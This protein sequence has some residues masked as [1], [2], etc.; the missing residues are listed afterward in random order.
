MS[1]RKV[2]Y[3]DDVLNE[4]KKF[5]SIT[6]IGI[7]CAESN[8]TKASVLCD[9]IKLHCKAVNKD[10]LRT[11]TIET[12]TDQFHVMHQVCSGC[13]ETQP[14]KEY[15]KFCSNC[16]VKFTNKECDD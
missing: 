4:I 1:N 10:I 2:V 7:Y 12:I 5:Y 3:R 15:P 6:N 16:G 11:G 14:W 13:G 9:A 8:K